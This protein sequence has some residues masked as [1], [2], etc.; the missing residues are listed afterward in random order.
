MTTLEAYDVGSLL[1]RGG[2]AH[3]YRA[4]L[5]GSVHQVRVRRSCRQSFDAC[6]VAPRP[7]AA[8]NATV[9]LGHFSAGASS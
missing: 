9:R 8:T 6:D 5:R 1:G 3:V 7:A 4:R 2:F